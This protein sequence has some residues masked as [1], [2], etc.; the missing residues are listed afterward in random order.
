M[1]C[2]IFYTAL[3]DAE[4]CSI[5]HK[6]ERQNEYASN[7]TKFQR[8]VFTV[9]DASMKSQ[10]M[11]MK[12]ATECI[13]FEPYCW[14]CDASCFNE[15]VSVGKQAMTPATVFCLIMVM[16][17]MVVVF[18]NE[19]IMV[20][21]SMD[22]LG[23]EARNI[24]YCFD[25]LVFVVGIGLCVTGVAALGEVDEACGNADCPT[26]VPKLIVAL[27]FFIMITAA[28][29]M[30]AVIMNNQLYLRAANMT[31]VLFGFI[32]LLLVIFIGITSGT[33][34]ENISSGYESNYQRFRKQIEAVTPGYCTLSDDECFEIT[35]SFGTENKFPIVEG[36]DEMFDPDTL[37]RVQLPVT[38]AYLR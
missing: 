1:A 30:A 11:K 37:W 4:F 26:L 17:V 31:M 9:A 25:I 13:S 38:N 28:V 14:E 32:L 19:L 27:G 33:I 35:S 15:A 36:S 16:C 10:Y 24:S 18:W 22:T 2:T 3:R 23:Y 7:C 6:I 29:A 8:G 21:E 34:M 12:E 20:E 5:A